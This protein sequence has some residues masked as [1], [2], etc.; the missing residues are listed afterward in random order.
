MIFILTHADEDKPRKLTWKMKKGLADNSLRR[1]GIKTE[2][3]RRV[4]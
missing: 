2:E 3:R 4:E 1:I